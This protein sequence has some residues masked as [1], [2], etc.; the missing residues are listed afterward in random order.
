MRDD[1]AGLTLERMVRG[2]A[3]IGAAL[4]VSLVIFLL[5][6]LGRGVR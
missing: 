4:L 6:V 5:L 2:A 3:V 1:R